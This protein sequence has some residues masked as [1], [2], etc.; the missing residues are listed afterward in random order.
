MD[1]IGNPDL[2]VI[3]HGPYWLLHPPG[4]P[5]RHV[6]SSLPDHA[7]LYPNRTG[8]RRIWQK[9]PRANIP[10]LPCFP[11]CPGKPVKLPPLAPPQDLQSNPSSDRAPNGWNPCRERPTAVVPGLP[12]GYQPF[13]ALH[14]IMCDDPPP[15]LCRITP[16]IMTL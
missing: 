11:R 16:L 13:P 9:I 10:N 4:S 8:P 1:H 12:A 5:V 2:A 7:P 6:G 15:V 14:P 3:K